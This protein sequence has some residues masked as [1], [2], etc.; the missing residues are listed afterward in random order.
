MTTPPIWWPTSS[1]SRSISIWGEKSRPGIAWIS[2][3]CSTR[4][5]PIS[6]SSRE[7]LHP[8]VV[9]RLP[10]LPP[11][12]PDLATL[13]PPSLAARAREVVAARPPP[14]P[15]RPSVT[16]AADPFPEIWEGI[17]NGDYWRQI[18]A[19]GIFPLPA[20]A[21]PAEPVPATE[22]ATVTL[23]E[24]YLKQGHLPEAASTFREVLEREP[25]NL[26]A[27]EGLEEIELQQV[28]PIAPVAEV[29]SKERKARA[30]K[31]LSSS[32]AHGSRRERPLMFEKRLQ[33]LLQQINGALAVSLVDQD[34]IPVESAGGSD[35]LDLEA[36]AAELLAQTRSIA[37]DHR[38]LD[39]GEV[40][41][42]SVTTDRYTIL[43]SALDKGYYLLLVLGDKGIY[44]KA[45]FE[46]RRALLEFEQD[47]Y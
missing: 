21:A 33:H 18:A 3:P 38:E 30:L 44:G 15:V 16:P 13:V 5:I 4:V 6:S 28:P 20:G 41:Q 25:E 35:G 40:C 22:E 39:V 31:R 11:P 17:G 47:L 19:E 46:L 2:T 9:F 24:L 8:H 32:L 45:R 29:E 34:G 7:T 14:P 37:D 1:W 10:S 26:G 23:G 43:V 42:F 36:L 12:P 27:R